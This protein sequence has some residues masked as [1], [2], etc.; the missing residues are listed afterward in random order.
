M[1]VVVNAANIQIGSFTFLPGQAIAIPQG[2]D[3][4]GVHYAE[5]PSFFAIKDVPWRSFIYP[6][7][8]EIAKGYNETIAK[9]NEV[10]QGRYK[11]IPDTSLYQVANLP[12]NEGIASVID[13]TEYLQ[14]CPW[15]RFLYSFAGSNNTYNGSFSVSHLGISDLL[16]FDY[17]PDQNLFSFIL[18]SAHLIFT[19]PENGLLKYSI[20]GEIKS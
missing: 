6:A 15:V 2:G 11:I 17:F 12:Q 7:G 13:I 16:E 3:N 1:S 19:P 4:I 18:D 8:A 9:L 10:L 20:V 5:N 14:S